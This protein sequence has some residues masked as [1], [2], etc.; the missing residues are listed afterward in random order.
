MNIDQAALLRMAGFRLVEI[1]G[2]A[3]ELEETA[4]EVRR[5]HMESPDGYENGIAEMEDIL[6][7]IRMHL[8][9][10]PDIAPE[11]LSA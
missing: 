10:M 5:N 6:G 3:T 7:I 8:D 11:E 4:L 9:A 2:L 1:I